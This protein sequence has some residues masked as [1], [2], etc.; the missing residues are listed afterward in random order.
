MWCAFHTPSAIWSPRSAAI[1]VVTTGL[2]VPGGAVDAAEGN[3]VTEAKVASCSCEA[4]G[5]EL[6]LELELVNAAVDDVDAVGVWLPWCSI[7]MASQQT[8]VRVLR[9]T[10]LH[11]VPVYVCGYSHP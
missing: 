8:W 11:V 9:L 7:S 1:R 10:R 5:L 6:E 2:V 4:V 3:S